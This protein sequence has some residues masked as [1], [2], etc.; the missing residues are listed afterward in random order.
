MRRERAAHAHVASVAGG[1][2]GPN[3]IL[4]VAE[5]LAMRRGADMQRLVFAAAGLQRHLDAPPREMV[6]EWE[7]ALLQRALVA[8]LGPDGAADISR[9]AG[10]LTGD[11]LLAHRIPVAAQR[12]LGVLPRRV[13]A[14]LLTIAIARHAWTFAGSGQFS[15]RFVPFPRLQ[16]ARSPLCRLLELPE[17]ACHYFSATFARVYGA[18][19]RTDVAVQE[20]ACRATG[21]PACVFEVRWR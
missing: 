11:Y 19:L 21:A 20:I 1:V 14:R 4:R 6:D 9:L 8:Q 3:A 2:I 17:P 16:L 5:A 7:V 15:Y 13:A 18:I 10:R 12:G